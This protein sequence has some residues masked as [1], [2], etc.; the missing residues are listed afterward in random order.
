[1]I[2]S[3]IS[4]NQICFVRAELVRIQLHVVYIQ[5]ERK[6]WKVEQRWWP[7]KQWNCLLLVTMTPWLRYQGNV[8]LFTAEPSWTTARK[9]I[10]MS[11]IQRFSSSKEA[12]KREKL[13]ENALREEQELL[14]VATAELTK[15]K[16]QLRQTSAELRAWQQSNRKTVEKQ[17]K[18]IA[19]L[20][21]ENKDSQLKLTA[22]T[23]KWKRG[24]SYQGFQV[25]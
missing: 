14:S 7:G 25:S 4:S 20:E 1:M 13:M 24:P 21:K 5:L 22:I 15:I 9:L 11:S 17:E 23:G 18:A 8:R 10:K 12:N 6:E 2:Q 3:I 16:R 19:L